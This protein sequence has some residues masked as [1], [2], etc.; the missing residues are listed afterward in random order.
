MSSS[1]TF[2]MI[3]LSCP[4]RCSTRSV[5]PAA[6]ECSRRLAV[7]FSEQGNERADLPETR[8]ECGLC[9]GLGHEKFACAFQ[10]GD[11]HARARGTPRRLFHDPA[12]VG[13][14][15]VKMPGG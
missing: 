4:A 3:Q 1:E 8:V 7:M 5:Q 11:S 15:D 9:Y 10:S 12:Q 14:A 6:F 2:P 13:R